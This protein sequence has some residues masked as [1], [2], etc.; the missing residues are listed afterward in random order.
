[1]TFQVDT[2]LYDRQYGLRWETG[3]RITKTGVEEFSKRF[4]KIVEIK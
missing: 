3:T 4:R 2:F 1:M